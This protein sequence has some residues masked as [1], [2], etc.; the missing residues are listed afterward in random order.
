MD[1]PW[2]GEAKGLLRAEIKR[3]DSTYPDVAD[4]LRVLGVHQTPASIA[5]KISRGSF[6]AAF[7]I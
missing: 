4:R 6:S 5:N 2:Y 7:L 3:R 1:D